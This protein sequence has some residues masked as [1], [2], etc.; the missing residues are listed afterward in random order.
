MWPSEHKQVTRLLSAYID[1]R[2]NTREQ[3]QIEKHLRTCAECRADLASL[4]AT[5]QI[6]HALPAMRLPR[7]FTL[8]RAMARQP[9]PSWAFPIFRAATVLAAVLL[10]VV[11]GADL[12]GMG[13]AAPGNVPQPTA[14]REFVAMAP[15]TVPPM[16]DVATQTPSLKAAVENYA[17]EAAPA[18]R[19]MPPT[20]LPPDAGSTGAGV[21][22]PA[23]APL[24]APAM[25]PTELPPGGGDTGAFGV[26]SSVTGK[27]PP[28]AGRAL[29]EDLTAT[30]Q[31]LPVSPTVE[32]TFAV[33]DTMT[34]Q[35]IAMRPALTPGAPTAG[36][37]ETGARDSSAPSVL[38]AVEV[39]LAGVTLL[40]GALALVTSGRIRR[41]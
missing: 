6:V 16:Q 33:T 29:P 21:L 32:H 3:T 2:V 24:A 5:V 23:V 26:N 30:P 38:R 36:D 40:L 28:G 37:A 22:P 12:A 7:S 17:T 8:P 35:A 4:R 1:K 39:W 34:P 27:L 19:L 13:R 18:A 15:V 41:T 25:L 20:E 10:I 14:Q 9:R 31:D 11:M